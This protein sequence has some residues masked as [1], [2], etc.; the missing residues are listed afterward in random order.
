M[1]VAAQLA[2]H[3][4]QTGLAPVAMPQ[5]VQ[6]EIDV[7][8]YPPRRTPLPPCNYGDGDILHAVQPDR[9]GHRLVQV[10]ELLPDLSGALLADGV[11]PSAFVA[12]KRIGE[13]IH[14]APFLWLAHA[15]VVGQDLTHRTRGNPEEMLFIR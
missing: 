3:A 8:A 6:S 10:P 11:E 13:V 5:P 2:D 1:G 9:L 12:D 4:I 7:L 15:G 14:G